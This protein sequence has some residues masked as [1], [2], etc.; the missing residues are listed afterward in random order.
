MKSFEIPYNFDFE[1]INFLKKYPLLDIYSIYV[2]PF[3]EH[4]LSAKSYYGNIPLTSPRDIEIYKAHLNYINQ[5]FPNKIMLLLQQNNQILDNQLLKFYIN[6]G[7]SKF[8]VGSLEQGKNIKKILPN[9]ELTG[10]ITMKINKEMLLNK[11]FNIFQG[12]VL[13]F[14]Y[15]RNI[16]ALREMPTQFDYSLLVNCTCHKTCS[17]TQHW[18][19]QT[20]NIEQKQTLLCPQRKDPSFENSIF[21]PN[22]DLIFFNEYISHIKLQGREYPTSKIIEDIY[23]YTSIENKNVKRNYDPKII[24]NI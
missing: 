16:C 9:A 23:N 6:L 7:I 5:Y 20:K 19:A 1:L 13:W 21:I 3:R 17:G 14:P 2:A 12:F 22:Y 11:D 8:C 18:L 24:Y 15:N 10:S 4:Y